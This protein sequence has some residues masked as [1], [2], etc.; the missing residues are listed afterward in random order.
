MRP[1]YA[2]DAKTVENHASDSIVR[3][4]TC[5]NTGRPVPSGAVRPVRPIRPSGFLSLREEPK[6]GRRTPVRESGGKSDGHGLPLPLPSPADLER[7]VLGRWPH[8]GKATH[9]LQSS[10]DQ[11][12]S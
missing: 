1:I 9:A 12:K 5:I 4:E 6:T 7:T 8:Q 2:P 3:Y 10:I 11:R